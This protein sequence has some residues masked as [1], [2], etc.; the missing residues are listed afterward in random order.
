MTGEINFDFWLFMA[1]LGLFLFGMYHLEKGLNGLAGKSFRNLLEK[2]TNQPWKG[3][4][5]GA[6]VTAVV[7]S[8]S[9]VMLLVVAFLGAG[10]MPLTSAIGV[11]LGANLGTTVT[12]WIVATLGFKVDISNLSFPFLAIGTFTYVM[13]DRRKN[14]KNIGS[15]L[16]GFG[17]LF[18]GLDYLKEAIEDLSTQ[19]NL[20][21]FVGF[22]LWV[23]VVIG[24]VITALIQSSSAMIVIVLSVLYSGMID[25][26]QAMSMIIGANIGTTSTLILASIKGPADKKRLAFVNVFFNV[27][28]GTVAFVFLEESIDFVLNRLHIAEPLMELVLLNTLLNL[29]GIILF[30]PF[31]GLISQFMQKRFLDKKDEPHTEFIKNATVDVPDLALQSIRSELT[32][33]F[34]LTKDFILECMRIDSEKQ[35]S[36][37][38]IDS[39]FSISVGELE[40]YAFLK[41]VEDEISAFYYRLQEQNLTAPESKLLSFYMHQLRELI[42]A[43]KE[44]KDVH[45]N[46][47]AIHVSEDKVA[48]EILSDLQQLVVEKI[49]ELRGYINSDVA[50]KPIGIQQL[51]LES[52]YQKKINKL[53]KTTYTSQ[54]VPI[55]TLTNVIRK[56]VQSME[57][58]SRS[59]LDKVQED[60]MLT[61]Q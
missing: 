19:I 54:T 32:N 56:T 59:V 24:I 21:E 30:F 29:G 20:S 44:I 42:Y 10:L 35:K 17:L 14:L 22:G 34:Y 8:S 11:V 33:L 50:Q 6:S 5:T 7:Q 51:E 49:E 13:L 28:S 36:V 12:A 46:I 40:K 39:F 47:Y 41:K 4:L 57:N 15:F 27:V 60:E 16:I 2:V 18:L 53:Y 52:F 9:L 45:E 31:I 26:Y 38:F 25:I 58:L 23:F 43:A 37:R 61:D 55:S 3:V 1:G 48:L